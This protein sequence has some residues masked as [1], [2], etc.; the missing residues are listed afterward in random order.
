MPRLKCAS[1]PENEDGDDLVGA[2]GDRDRRRDVVEDQQRR[3]EEAA[4]DAE[5]ARQESDRCAHGEQDEGH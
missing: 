4:A 1:E 3:D 5:H 2:G